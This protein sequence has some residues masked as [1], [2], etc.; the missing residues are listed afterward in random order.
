[1]V[2]SFG[3][4]ARGVSQCLVRWAEWV[5]LV[6]SA[7]GLAVSKVGD[8]EQGGWVSERWLVGR[9]GLVACSRSGMASAGLT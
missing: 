7:W 4:R 3:E 5:M 6:G 2:R 9:I 1:M 8:H